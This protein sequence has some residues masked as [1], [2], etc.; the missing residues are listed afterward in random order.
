V[1]AAS[2]A[3]PWDV[4][5]ALVPRL[6]ELS[7]FDLDLAAGKGANMGELAQAGFAVPDGFPP[8]H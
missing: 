5:A 2:S 8:D 1:I 4:S 3:A 6:A 7:A